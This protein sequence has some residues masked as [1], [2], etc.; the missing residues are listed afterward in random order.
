MI[1]DDL[2]FVVNGPPPVAPLPKI[3]LGKLIYDS[4]LTNSD[5]KEAMVSKKILTDNKKL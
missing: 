2:K 3:S 1:E 4:L 5:N